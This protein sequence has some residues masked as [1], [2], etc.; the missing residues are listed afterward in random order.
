MFTLGLQNG[1]DTHLEISNQVAGQTFSLKL[2]NNATAA[3]T[4]TFD[5]QFEFEGGTA[6]TATAA[7]N[8]VDI[9]TF[10]TFDGSNVQCVGSKNF[11]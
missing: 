6:F 7:T 11:S 10:T 2:T 8:A 5:P 1:V 3:G 9:L 4:I